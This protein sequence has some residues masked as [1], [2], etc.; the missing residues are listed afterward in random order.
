MCDSPIRGNW[1]PI[2]ETCD[3]TLPVAA[4]ELMYVTWGVEPRKWLQFYFILHAGSR[5]TEDWITYAVKR[6]IHQPWYF[7]ILS[8][9]DKIMIIQK[10]EKGTGRGSIV[11]RA[12][13][14]KRQQMA[15]ES[16]PAKQRHAW[17]ILLVSRLLVQVDIG[18]SSRLMFASGWGPAISLS[19]IAQPMRVASNRDQIISVKTTPTRLSCIGFFTEKNYTSLHTVLKKHQ[20]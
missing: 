10:K 1:C 7:I 3:S 20:G 17:E 5:W 4:I 2:A 6:G 14:E 12:S 13:R 19:L 11:T 16:V 18:G 15:A 9:G 8:A